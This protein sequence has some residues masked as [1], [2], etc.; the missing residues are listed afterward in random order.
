MVI[1]KLWSYLKSA[2]SICLFAKFRRKTKMLKFG[3]KNALFG[4]FGLEL[5]KNYC[6][7]LNQHPQ[8]SQKRVFNSFSEFWYRVRFF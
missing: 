5:Q 8:I 4:D 6:L 7:I 2:P 1:K 3:T